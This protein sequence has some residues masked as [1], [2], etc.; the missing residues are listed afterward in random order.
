LGP[1][2]LRRLHDELA[3]ARNVHNAGVGLGEA[4]R[5]LQRLIETLRRD[6]A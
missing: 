5:L 2:D 4:E 6:R 1:E 3:S